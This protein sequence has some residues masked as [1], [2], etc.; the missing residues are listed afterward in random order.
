MIPSRWV[1]WFEVPA[2][3]RIVAH[4][5]RRGRR[6][7]RKW[8]FLRL[9]LISPCNC[10]HKSSLTFSA[11]GVLPPSSSY[12]EEGGI[13]LVRSSNVASSGIDYES[14]VKVCV[15][16]AKSLITRAS[17]AAP[18]DSFAEG[19]INGIQQPHRAPEQYPN[20]I[21]FYPCATP[22][23]PD[24]ISFAVKDRWHRGHGLAR[25]ATVILD[26]QT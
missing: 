3:D 7:V 6:K 17:S 25:Q 22:P 9:S 26:T 21:L 10:W 8:P 5:S 16:A 20:K 1:I 11:G 12:L 14:A 13:F 24:R 2:W 18:P 23:P 4:G 15:S 19:K